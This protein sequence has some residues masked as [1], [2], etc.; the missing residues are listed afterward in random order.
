MGI[1][2]AVMDALKS[3]PAET[4]E[5]L[6]KNIL[7]CGG[8]ALFPGMKERLQKEIRALAPALYKVYVQITSSPISAA[9]EGGKMYLEQPDAL[10]NFITREQYEEGG[11]DALFERFDI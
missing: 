3:C 5:H 7:I 10:L 4:I 1:P 8:S 9:W 2:E 11:H 6:L